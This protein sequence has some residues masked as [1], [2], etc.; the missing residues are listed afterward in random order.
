[1]PTLSRPPLEVVGGAGLGRWPGVVALGAAFVP[2][3]CP[4]PWRSPVVSAAILRALVRASDDLVS[5]ANLR[6]L[7]RASE[8]LGSLAVRTWPAWGSCMQSFDALAAGG[9]SGVGRVGRRDAGMPRPCGRSASSGAPA[10]PEA[11][12]KWPGGRHGCRDRRSLPPPVTFSR[13]RSAGA[14]RSARPRKSGRAPPPYRRRGMPSPTISEAGGGRTSSVTAKDAA[15]RAV[16]G[17][18][19]ARGSYTHVYAKRPEMV[20]Q[21]GHAI[22]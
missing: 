9:P 11:G 22:K 20:V 14:P 12:P 5:A 13:A 15:K 18:L 16:S 7:V 21:R 2:R 6:A 19:D 8:D 10:T 4:H 17:T 3:S 1:M